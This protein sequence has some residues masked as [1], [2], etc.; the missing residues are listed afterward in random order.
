MEHRA[1]RSGMLKSICT[2]LS[3]AGLQVFA[4]RPII[5]QGQNV[6]PLIVAKSVQD[7]GGIKVLRSICTI[8]PLQDS[9]LIQRGS[10]GTQRSLAYLENNF[11]TPDDVIA[12][13]L[14]L[15]SS[16]S[17]NDNNDTCWPP[18]NKSER[19]RSRDN[20]SDEI[21]LPGGIYDVW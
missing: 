17:A 9:W 8:V 1:E 19:C 3:E 5:I 13:I 12:A 6:I 20:C 16:E 21:S 2:Q 7:R 11:S 4:G 10:K 14:H 18:K 15:Y